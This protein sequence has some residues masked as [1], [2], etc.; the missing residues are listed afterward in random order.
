M[1]NSSVQTL[2]EYINTSACGTQ[3]SVIN[4]VNIS[5]QTT[6]SGKEVNQ[7]AKLVSVLD[8]V[9]PEDSKST[10]LKSIQLLDSQNIAD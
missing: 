3:T 4:S 2:S 10:L 1:V 7:L 9:L 5:T 8:E 6:L